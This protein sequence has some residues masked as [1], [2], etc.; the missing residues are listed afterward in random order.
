VQFTPWLFGNLNVDLARPRDLDAAK[1][2]NYLPLAPTFSSTAALKF[3]LASGFNG[4]ISYRYLHDRPANEDNTLVAKGYFITDLS[5]NYTQKRY[6]AGLS[7]ENL[8]NRSWNEGQFAYTSRLR[9]EP[10]PVD[11]VSFTPGTP[12]FAKLKLTVFF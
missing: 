11:D 3:H 4:G 9:H 2:A 12:F 1:G 10:A 5:L 6:E 7:V 8:L